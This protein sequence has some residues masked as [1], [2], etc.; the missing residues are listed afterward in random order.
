MTQMLILAVIIL[1]ACV[2]SGLFK[3]RWWMVFAMALAVILPTTLYGDNLVGT[4]V[5]LEYYF[6]QRALEGWDVS[7]AH[8]MN[9]SLGITLLAPVLER[10]LHIPMYW[11]FKLIIPIA[12][13]FTPAILYLIFKKFM[14][15]KSAFL[16]AFFIIAVPTFLIEIPALTRQML[17]YPFLSL[18]FLFTLSDLRVRYK[19]PAMIATGLVVLVTHYSIGV[20]L[21]AMMLLYVVV[22]AIFRIFKRKGL[23]PLWVSAVVLLIFVLSSL[24]YYGTVAGGSPLRFMTAIIP[25]PAQKVGPVTVGYINESLLPGNKPAGTPNEDYIILTGDPEKIINSNYLVRSYDTLM[26]MALGLDFLEASGSGKAFRLFQ[27]VTQIL[28]AIGLIYLLG[29]KRHQ[30]S[31][32]YLAFVIVSMLILGACIIVP[33]FSAVLNATRWYHLAL[34]FLAPAVIIA[35]N[36]IFKNRIG[37]FSL[38]LVAYFLFT[39]GLVFEELETRNID[40]AE[41]PYSIAL[42]DSRLDLSGHYT[43]DDKA[44]AEWIYRS[45][46]DTVWSDYFGVV[47][48][49]ERMALDKPVYF[50]PEDMS[51]IPDGGY[52][53]VRSWNNQK[54]ELSYW[55]G[56]GSR[57]TEEFD[58]FDGKTVYQSGDSEVVRIAK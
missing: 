3:P 54:G 13:C 38:L 50:I 48:L 6:A 16:S 46:I 49:Q 19:L 8:P 47:Y 7:I 45:E 21:V 27:Y 36:L 32:E 43:P 39:S 57:R 44:V 18:F 35:G 23:A 11:T 51:K 14:D 52:I 24:G 10:Y 34:F 58:G 12:Y 33:G 17:A 42:S 56:A 37:L 53:F 1:V 20:V 40:R 28:L 22:M 25:I 31:D 4:D 55:T 30:F 29:W 2:A 5:H 26:R 9:S 41:L 15:A